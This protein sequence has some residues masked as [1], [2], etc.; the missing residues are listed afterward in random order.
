MKCYG[1]FPKRG[2]DSTLTSTSG[3]ILMMARLDHMPKVP[4]TK[5]PSSKDASSM[6]SA[7]VEEDLGQNHEAVASPER[8]ADRTKAAEI[9]VRQDVDIE[10]VRRND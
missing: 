5:H 4:Y 8:N 2:V 7:W 10:S 9:H 6:D 3:K 1:L